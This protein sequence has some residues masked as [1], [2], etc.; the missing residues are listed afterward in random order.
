MK[1]S[2]QFLVL[3]LS[4]IVL[5]SCNNSTKNLTEESVEQP[6]LF[7]LRNASGI[8]MTVTNYGGKIV[9][10]SVPDRAGNNAD[11]VL[12]YDSLSQYPSGNPYFGALI[13]RYGNRIAGGEFSIG[14]NHYKLAQNNGPNA[15]HGGPGGFNN[16]YWN[17]EVY[18][19]DGYQALDLT[20]ESP[21]GEEGYPGAL[22][23]RVTYLLNNDNELVI[24]YEATTNKPTV[25]NLTHHSFFNLHGAGNGNILDHQFE[26]FADRYLP[27]DSV[28]IPTGELR[29][30]S[31][32]P[33]DFL[34]PHAAG[35]RIEES[36]EQLK[37]GRGYDHCFVLNKV[38][39]NELSLAARVTDSLSGRVMEVF[40]TE[41][42][43]QFYS[44]NFLTGKDIGK[45]NIAYGFRSA[46]CLE[47]QHYPDSPNKPEFPSV[48]LMPDQRYTQRTIY[49]FSAR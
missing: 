3:S 4:S 28:L 48:L 20:Y 5:F 11:I 37:F 19:K 36:D 16:V 25:V 12:G 24:D 44:G 41:P 46:F 22:S 23:V 38:K 29:P 27:V 35:E 10:L 33:F 8:E 21:D 2:F 13:G 49:R 40:T 15:L 31:G 30:V 7:T 42:A 43:M 17:A 34:M 9:T 6:Q 26:I 1:K 47:A 39:A 45:G 18:E 32:T 14:D